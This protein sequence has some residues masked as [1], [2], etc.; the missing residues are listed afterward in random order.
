MDANHVMP[1]TLWL[2]EY[3]VF[4]LAEQ[5]ATFLKSQTQS[6]QTFQKHMNEN[7]TIP[8]TTL[9][10]SKTHFSWFPKFG[11]I[12]LHRLL[13]D[14]SYMP[15]FS[16]RFSKISQWYPR[17]IAP[18]SLTSTSMLMYKLSR[19]SLSQIQSSTLSSPKGFTLKPN[20]FHIQA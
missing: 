10:K 18:K 8:D 16:K 14:R 19:V 5:H 11:D 12:T 9:A 3:L 13:F 17:W 20:A 6:N 15:P 2:H 1:P 7:T 4:T